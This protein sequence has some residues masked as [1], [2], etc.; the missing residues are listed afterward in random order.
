VVLEDA[1]GWCGRIV[2]LDAQP[3]A[4][5][6]GLVRLFFRHGATYALGA[7]LSQGIAFLL[8]PFF[9]HVFSP[10][11][12]GVIDLVGLVMNLV[13]LTVALEISSGLG[14][15]FP[16]ANGQRDREGYASTALIF[17]FLAYTVTLAAALVFVRPLTALIFGGGVKTSTLVLGVAAMWCSGMLY[18]TQDLLRWQLRPRAFAAVSIVTATVVTATSAVLVLAFDMGVNGAIAGQ[19]I[20]FGCAAAVALALSRQLFHLQLDRTKLRRMLAYSLPLIPANLGVFLNIYVDRLAIRARLT[21]SDVGLYGAAY[22]LSIVTSLILLGFQGALLPLVLSRHEQPETPRDLAHIFRLFCAIA[23][24]TFLLVSLFADEFLRVLTRPA[25]YKAADVVPFIV[26]AA[27]LSGMSVFAPGL[28]VARRTRPIVV[29]SVISGVV[30]AGLA[31]ALARPLGIKGPALAFLIAALAGFAA[32]MV[33][34]QRTYRAPH[35]WRRLLPTTVVIVALAVLGRLVLGGTPDLLSVVGKFALASA[36]CVVV[37]CVLLSRYERLELAH[38]PRRLAREL[39]S[40]L[41]TA[42]GQ[43][44]AKR[45]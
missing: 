9:A 19:L 45:V 27:F 20:G 28:Y 22:R 16:E 24:V 32:L 7:F 2:S 4:E 36:G 41:R 30:N 10:R 38:S 40:A 17:T 42:R 11:D 33:L 23:L 25:F 37:A 39:H 13:N 6:S 44:R 1:D 18:L 15:F 34:S 5:S 12:Y 31:F 21:L 14:R 3:E 29:I 43:R 8:F 35:D 26:A